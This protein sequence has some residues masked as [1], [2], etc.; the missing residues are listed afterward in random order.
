MSKP[1][2][3]NSQAAKKMLRLTTLGYS[4]ARVVA[5][6]ERQGWISEGEVTPAEWEAHLQSLVIVRHPQ[7]RFEAPAPALHQTDTA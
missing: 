1:L 5:F 2:D 4:A 6:A 7:K 3:P